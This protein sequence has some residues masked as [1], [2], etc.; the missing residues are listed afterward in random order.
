ML[1]DARLPTLLRSCPKRIINAA[2]AKAAAGLVP[3]AVTPQQ[4]KRI[5]AMLPPS[6]ND[7]VRS[8]S[9][10]PATL[11]VLKPAV[12]GFLQCL[13]DEIEVNRQV[14]ATKGKMSKAYAGK[15]RTPR[16]Y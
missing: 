4:H 1:S 15:P 2:D 11:D 14:I 16:S 6:T 5:L 10:D 12:F 7:G 13:E 9:I 8:G 3:A